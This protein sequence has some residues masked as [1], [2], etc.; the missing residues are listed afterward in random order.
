MRR[1]DEIR[2]D[3]RHIPPPCVS[4]SLGCVFCVCVC[5]CVCD[6][7]VKQLSPTCLLDVTQR[8]LRCPT[9]E[10]SPHAG[11]PTHSH[12]LSHLTLS[13]DMFMPLSYNC[14]YLI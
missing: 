1:Q 10:G 3:P 11:G 8:L 2:Q 7:A 5:E 13:K 12:T 4:L 14:L 6:S 9:C